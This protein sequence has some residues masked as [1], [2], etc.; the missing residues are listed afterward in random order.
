M[1]SLMWTIWMV[2]HPDMSITFK[3]LACAGGLM[4]PNIARTAAS[5]TDATDVLN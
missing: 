1:E 3:P 4:L 2:E 5:N